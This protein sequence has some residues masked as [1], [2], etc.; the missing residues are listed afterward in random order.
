MNDSQQADAVIEP[1]DRSANMGDPRAFR[2]SVS[3]IINNFNYA[4]FLE[5]AV[6]SALDQTYPDVEVIVVDDG[7][8]DESRDILKKYEGRAFIVFNAGCRIAKGQLIAFLDSDDLLFP[9]AI[10][11]VVNA[12][13]SGIVKMQFPLQILGPEG[14]T[15]FVMPRARLSEGDLLEKLLKTGRYVTSPTSGNV[16]ARSFLHSIFPIPESEWKQSGDGYINNCA[17]FYGP[18]AAVRRPL[19]IY[20]VHENSMSC[21]LSRGAVDLGQLEKLMRHAFLEKSLIENLAQKRGLEFSPS[22]LVS[23][24]MHL[25]LSLSLYRLKTR[26][27]FCR[28]KALLRSAFAMAASVMRSDE[29]TPFVKAQHIVWAAGVAMLPDAVANKFIRLAFDHAPQSRILGLL[30]RR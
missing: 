10:Q 11:T 13:Q 27:G 8:T 23:H 19:G 15:G 25:K 28:M 24:W 17:P 9:D 29:L 7:S 14:S 12:W 3:I 2:P 4:S 16:F 26:P 1:S 18:V 5:A 20:R 22:L 30:R 21:A 6:D